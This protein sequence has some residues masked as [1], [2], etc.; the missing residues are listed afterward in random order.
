MDIA[1]KVLALFGLRDRFQFV[2]G[3]DVG[4][5]KTDQLARLLGDGTVGTASTM[6]GDRAIDVLAAKKNSLHAIGVLWGHGS[7]DEL[8]Q[9]GADRLLSLPTDLH[10]FLALRPA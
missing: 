7:H 8:I 6:I 3:G 5:A 4:V 10:Q 1:E 2:C 9:A